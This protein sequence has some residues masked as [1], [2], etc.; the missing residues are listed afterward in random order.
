MTAALYTQRIER[1]RAAL[2]PFANLGAVILAEAPPE[3]ETVPVFKSASGETFA[4][5]LDDFR[6]AIAAILSLEPA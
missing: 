3:A 6:D 5:R 2:G 4:L 1:L